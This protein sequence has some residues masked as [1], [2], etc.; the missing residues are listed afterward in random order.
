MFFLNATLLQQ[1]ENTYGFSL[2]EEHNVW[3]HLKTFQ[4]EVLK[5]PNSYTLI[6]IER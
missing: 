2:N 6:F 1:E 5:S 4:D 3:K